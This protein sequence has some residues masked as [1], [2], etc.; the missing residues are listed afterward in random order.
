MSFIPTANTA[1]VAIEGVY[2]SGSI[3]NTLWFLHAVPFTGA[4]LDTLLGDLQAGWNSAMMPLLSDSYE[5]ERFVATAQ[6]SD[7]APV[8]NLP[9]TPGTF[10]GHTTGTELPAN[11]AAVVSFYT[12][13]RGRS[14]RGRV[15]IGGLCTDQL[16]T[17]K[18]F[19]A[20]FIAALNTGFADL[21][22]YMSTNG[23]THVVVSH[24]HDKVALSAG[25]ARTVVS[26]NVNAGVDTMRKRVS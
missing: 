24:R 18:T 8:R 21:A 19:T 22:T 3:V 2:G 16:Q 5:V 1:R 4:D 11:V 7:T 10:G 25:V 12:A 17:P 23:H 6:D 20:A 13:A 15:F 14:G 9:V 26:Y